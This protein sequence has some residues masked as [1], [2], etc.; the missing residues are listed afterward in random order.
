MIILNYT[1]IKQQLLL[2][3]LH[4]VHKREPGLPAGM[5]GGPRTFLLE[6]Q[7]QPDGCAAEMCSTT[8]NAP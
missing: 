2:S 8:S 7:L 1:N 6:M 3:L 4:A 5:Q